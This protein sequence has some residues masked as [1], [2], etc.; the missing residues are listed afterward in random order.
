MGNMKTA[1]AVAALLL[2]SACGNADTETAAPEE[3]ET[4]IVAETDSMATDLSAAGDSVEQKMNELQS[5]LDSLN[6]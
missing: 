1:I 3:A 5:S 4:Q 2:A 6:N